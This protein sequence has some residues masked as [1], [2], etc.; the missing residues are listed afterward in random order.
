MLKKLTPIMAVALLLLAFSPSLKA[1]QTAT[2]TVNAT[3]AGVLYLRVDGTDAGNSLYAANYS[4][5]ETCNLGTLDAI[6]TAIAGGDA[7][8]TG[9]TGL[10]VNATGN[11]VANGVDDPSCVGSF[12]RILAATGGNDETAHANAALG[13]YARGS[14]V[15][16]YNLAVAAAVTGN[17]S[18]TVGQ[19]KYKLDATANSDGYIGYTDFTTSS[20]NLTSGAAG[21]I[22][23]LLFYDLGLLVEFDDAPGAYT[24]TLTYTLTTT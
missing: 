16:T 19:L 20:Q 21:A 14:R 17:A 4:T 15:T 22:R 12:Y 7:M 5:A 18:V 24:W 2:V 3:I 10:A 11:T 8:V 6:G 23:F 1:Q 13:V 9:I